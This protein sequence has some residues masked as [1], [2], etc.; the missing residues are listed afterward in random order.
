[1]EEKIL[2]L[3]RARIKDMLFADSVA[4]KILE[5][6]YDGVYPKKRIDASS[7]AS[8][9]VGCS[10]AAFSERTPS[11]PTSFDKIPSDK[12]SECFFEEVVEAIK[13][14]VAS[15]RLMMSKR[16]RI[17]LPEAFGYVLGTLL[18]NDKGYG[19]FRPVGGGSDRKKDVFVRKS[20]MKGALHR[21]TVLVKVKHSVRGAEAEI[22]KIV[23]RA[24][25]TFVG[26]LE[27]HEMIPNDRKVYRSLVVAENLC[28]A[29]NGDV[30][31]V[32]V[33][34]WG[35]GTRAIR[36]NITEILGRPGDKGIDILAIAKQFGLEAE[37]PPQVLAEAEALPKEMPLGSRRD[38]RSLP[39][40]TIDGADAKD[41]D[42]AISL[43]I[44]SS[45]EERCG[46]ES[47]RSGE[48]CPDGVAKAANAEKTIRT[49]KVKQP[50]KG[51]KYRLYV[52][53][54]D[55]SHYV[56]PG[57]DLD[58]EALRRGT[59]SYLL[60]RVI[61]MLP[62]R[63]SNDLCSLNAG[64]DRYAL[65]CMMDCRADG[66]II[67][68]EIVK[69]VI[70]VD[71]GLEYAGVSAFLG[72]HGSTQSESGLPQ[73]NAEADLQSLKQESSKCAPF[74][75]MLHAMA[76]L[77]GLFRKKRADRGAVD[78]D[79]PEAVIKL[80][81]DGF[82]CDILR[83]ERDIASLMIEDFMLAANETVAEHYYWLEL[84]FIYRVHEAPSPDK[85]EELKRYISLFGVSLKGKNENAGIAKLIQD[86]KGEQFE[87]AV[88]REALRSMMQ[89][90][91]SEE[92]LG[93]FGL[94]AKYY[95]HFTAP[96]RRYPDLFVHRLI[97]QYLQSESVSDFSVSGGKSGSG[98][99]DG[100]HGKDASG[101]NIISE[102]TCK[103]IAELSGECERNAE[104][105]ERKVEAMKMA[106]YMEDHIGEL[107]EGTVSG[108]MSYGIF[109][110]LDNLVE[111]LVH[112]TLM[113]DDEYEYDE[114]RL[115]LTGI[116]SG[117]VF[118]VG[119]R[120]EVLVAAANA[121]T[122]KVDFSL[123]AN[124]NLEK[125]SS[126]NRGRDYRAK[127]TGK[128]AGRN[129]GKKKDSRPK[130]EKSSLKS[131]SNKSS[132]TKASF[133][134][135]S[136]IRKSGKHKKSQNNSKN[137]PKIT[138]KNNRKSNPKKESRSIRQ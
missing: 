101:R 2:E 129:E 9:D 6:Y 15:G 56:T 110:Q 14:L 114:E 75:D 84:P 95:T 102:E 66:E 70:N 106:E 124:F 73:S 83:R 40:V 36:C 117:E 80:D 121:Q 58:K 104:S 12:T 34:G 20:D 68:H 85:I 45:G 130:R 69:S 43:E 131:S 41:I 87:M 113:P 19:F 91:Y 55:V 105:A 48:W 82:P 135:S 21:D 77:S 44:L 1:M 11:D 46:C 116:Q 118:A 88:S 78:F 97:S 60:D 30:V 24:T 94:A 137:N 119:D 112:V 42:D 63:L 65:T 31:M 23:K 57:S 18:I 126:R 54:A 90:R 128:S 61:P 4:E 62:T 132:S 28:G 47:G 120:A 96:I 67:S 133:S 53:I 49:G 26:T 92:C 59:S 81:E 29:K 64:E 111:G 8:K 98:N 37:F 39:T 32:R 125:K 127:S 25:E 50:A 52:H 79:F 7:A 33:V 76:E 115:T 17:G 86:I 72:N 51:L 22:I 5:E 138:S 93:H 99:R 123:I 134:P 136:K 108:V 107:F 89:A 27:G 122:G 10:D 100:L 3:F 103:M 109:V 16:G 74:A 38:F 71:A 13:H 35:D